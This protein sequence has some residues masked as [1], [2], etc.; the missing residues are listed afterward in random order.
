MMKHH[1]K[2]VDSVFHRGIIK[3][4]VMRYQKKSNKN[5]FVAMILVTLFILSLAP[6]S[7]EVTKNIAVS[8]VEPE[9]IVLEKFEASVSAYT[10]RPQ[11]TDDTPFIT[12][13]G[14]HVYDGGVACPSR[15]KFGTKILINDRVFKC[16]D[17]MNK[18]YREGNYFDIWFADYDLAIEHGR[19]QVEVSILK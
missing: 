1:S 11:E 15:Y 6:Y 17:R 18:R 8:E 2:N 12:A 13:N 19:R 16:N 4:P 14:E 10:S 3:G 9:Y 7:V 5:F